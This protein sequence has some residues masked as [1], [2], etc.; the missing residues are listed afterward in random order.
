MVVLMALFAVC[1]AFFV[2]SRS[3]ARPSFERLANALALGLA[4]F[5]WLPYLFARVWGITQGGWIS[6]GILALLASAGLAPVI[7][8]Q[9]PGIVA[10]GRATTRSTKADSLTPTRWWPG[11]ILLI[12]TVVLGYLLYNTSLHVRDGGLWSAGAGCE[13]MGLHATLANAFLHSHERILRPTYSIFPN[14]PLGYHFLPDF[15]AATAMALGSSIGFGFFATAAFALLALVSNLYCLAR[16]WLAPA[17]SVLAIFLFLFGGNMGIALLLRDLP[18]AGLFSHI[19]LEDYAYN[20]N[21]SLHYGNIATAV[22]L[23]MR[24]PLF[25]A[26]I[27][28]AAIAI[29]SRDSRPAVAEKIVA[30][31]LLGSLPLI[32]AHAFLA[33]SLCIAVYCLYN[34]V[35]RLRKWWPALIVA[36]ALAGPQLYWIHYQMAS[37]GA[38]F[39]R[40]A[41]GFLFETRLSWPAYWLLNGGLFAPLGIAAWFC[42]SRDLKRMTLPLLIVLPL[43]MAISFQPNTFDNIK[44]LLFF[45]LGSALLIA[46]F[47]QRSVQAGAGRTVIAATAVLVCTASGMLSWVHEANAPCEMASAANREFAA[48]VLATTDEHS[49]ILTAQKFNHPVPFLTGRT[50]VL[51]FHNW[52]NQH[53]I[54][55]E[56]R[57]A[58]VVEIYAGSEQARALIAEYG[59]TDIVVGPAER[60]EFPGL[61]EQFLATA[62]RAHTTYGEYTVYRLRR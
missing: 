26:P 27:A 2:T 29:F 18:A 49:V 33:V 37:S 7:F 24:T 1:T 57:A 39:I 31:I 20:F 17:Y 56:K 59:I 50:I 30:G 45:H 3:P 41:D 16:R 46:D 60:Q 9:A 10:R 51:G 6:F 40:L 48:Q 11:L 35:G 38:P 52:L 34:P 14:W 4:F 21:L 12:I 58:D 15:A 55:F 61:N 44:L 43:C 23:P 8:L 32:N 53:G 5:L 42:A 36:A 54:P 25:G 22:L 19:W 62:S 13:D 28:F 47:C